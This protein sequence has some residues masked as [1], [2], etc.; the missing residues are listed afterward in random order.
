MSVIGVSIIPACSLKNAKRECAMCRED[1]GTD[2]EPDPKP[3]AVDSKPKRN[4][5][6]AQDRIDSYTPLP[7]NHSKPGTTWEPLGKFKLDYHDMGDWV[8][9]KKIGV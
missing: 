8:C 5:L 4:K 1:R 7:K 6:V 2:E 3:K 9:A